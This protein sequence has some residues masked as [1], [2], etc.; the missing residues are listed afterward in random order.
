M[1][2]L[3]IGIFIGAFVMF[4]VMKMYVRPNWKD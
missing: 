2:E 4:V 3:L 1:I